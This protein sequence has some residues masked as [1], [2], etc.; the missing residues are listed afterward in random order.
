MNRGLNRYFSKKIHYG[1]KAH[2]RMPHISQLTGHADEDHLRHHFL[3]TRTAIVKKDI[4]VSKDM[5][6]LHTATGN[7]KWYCCFGK[8]SGSSSVRK[9]PFDPLV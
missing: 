5:E 1:Q 9:L 3:L 2:D 7:V 8:Q 6:P 4:N